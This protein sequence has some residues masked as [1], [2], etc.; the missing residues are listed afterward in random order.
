MES[1]SQVITYWT[2]G[3]AARASYSL[4][5]S[6]SSDQGKANA[7]SFGLFGHPI[8]YVF[9]CNLRHEDKPWMYKTFVFIYRPNHDQPLRQF[10]LVSRAYWSA[11]PENH[12]HIGDMVFHSISSTGLK[13]SRVLQVLGNST[14]G[15]PLLPNTHWEVWTLLHI[16]TTCVRPR[17]CHQHWWTIEHISPLTRHI[18]K[19]P[20]CMLV[21]VCET[22]PFILTE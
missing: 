18:L 22:P 9:Y 10:I 11:M 7:R 14:A 17:M 16:W 1:N 2:C 20:A 15:P 5:S 4:K 21:Y 3:L 8:N 12:I 6:A 19:K 13:K